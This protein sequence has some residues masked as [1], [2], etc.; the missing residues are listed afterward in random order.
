VTEPA[1]GTAVGSDRPVRVGLSSCFFHADPDRKVFTG[2]TLLYVEQ[3]MAHW[4][5]AGGVLVYPI[6]TPGDGPL[7]ITDWIADLDGLVLH[8]GA[9]VAPESYGESALR[10]EWAGDAVRDRYEFELVR[11]FLDQEKP[12]LG[13]C[14]G[15]QVLNVAL[16]GTLYQDLVEQRVTERVHRDAVAYDRNEHDLVVRAGTRL[17]ALV[18]HGHHRVNSVHHQGIKHLAPGL[19]A[20][21]WSADDAVV[22][23]VRLDADVWCSAVQWHP[24][25]RRTV[26]EHLLDDTPL[27]AEFLAQCHARREGGV[28]CAS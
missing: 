24:E 8:G 22:E 1:I 15:I 26:D 4:V 21:A 18:G 3:S 16:G 27:R 6:P 17:A 10:A 2:K 25:F 14:R 11:G 9:D 5:A 20:E 19:V 23:A 28:P 7:A 12:V 13:I